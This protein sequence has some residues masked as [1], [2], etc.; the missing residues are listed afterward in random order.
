MLFLASLALAQSIELVPLRSGIESRTTTV[1]TAG[2]DV[3]I[4][5]FISAVLD[6]SHYPMSASYFG[7]PA[8]E[9]STTLAKLP[10]GSTVAYQRSGGN[11]LLKSR[12]WLIQ[13]KVTKRTETVGEV[14]WFLIKE[15]VGA[16]G[17]FTGPYAEKLNAHR[18]DAVF[19]PYNHGTWRLDRT[20]K[21]VMYAAESDAGGS[22]PSWAVSESAVL[23]FPREMMKVRLGVGG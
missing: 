20:A 8:L 15:T 16:D 7:V 4:D 22:L 3:S 14:Q 17:S 21:T 6:A 19:T 10:D 23:A 13:L 2:V 11:A 12:Q 18:D 5:K 9:E 1:S